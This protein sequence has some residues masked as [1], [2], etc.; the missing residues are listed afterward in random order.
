MIKPKYKLDDD[1]LK[2]NF[3]KVY[4]DFG[5]GLTEENTDRYFYTT[6][7]EII[8]DIRVYQGARAMR[9]DPME[10]S[11]VVILK[12]ILAVTA[13]ERKVPIVETNGRE[14][15][16]SYYLF[17]TN[18][19]WFYLP[20]LKGEIESIHMVLEIEE[21]S[22]KIL[23]VCSRQRKNIEGVKRSKWKKLKDKML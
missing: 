11:G 7:E 9:I 20:V 23:D 13:E 10:N 16:P 18:D 2:K 14:I 12:E 8:V 17:D 19:P 4:Y 22:K 21:I 3:V 1:C 15:E 5:S 6:S